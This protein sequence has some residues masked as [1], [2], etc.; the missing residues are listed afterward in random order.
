MAFGATLASLHC[1][2]YN[3]IYNA[4]TA[5]ARA[6]RLAEQQ[7]V[8][9]AR[10]WYRRAADAAESVLSR[11]GNSEWASEA[12]YLAAQ[13][14][15][16]SG[17]CPEAEAHWRRWQERHHAASGQSRQDQLLAV[18]GEL[19]VASCALRRTG[20]V[21]DIGTDIGTDFGTD[22]WKATGTGTVTG[23]VSTA[24]QRLQALDGSADSSWPDV[25]R[26]EIRRWHARAALGAGEAAVADSLLRGLDDDSA[27]WE[28]LL[29]AV[30]TANWPRVERLLVERVR[31]NAFAPALDPVVV[32]LA[33]AAQFHPLRRVEA[34]L[35]QVATARGARAR[36]ALVFGDV[37]V[38]VGD[39]ARADSLF[40]NIVRRH[41]GDSLIAAPAAVRLLALRLRHVDAVDMLSARLVEH[42]TQHGTG[43]GYAQLREPAALF[44]VLHS[45]EDPSGAA[46]FLAGEVARD[47][48]HAPRLA[49]T[50]WESLLDRYPAAPLAPRALAALTLLDTARAGNWRTE[51]QARF[52][53]AAEARWQRQESMVD[54]ADYRAA[55]RL[56]EGRWELALRESAR[57]P[58]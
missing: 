34:E 17:A 40:T 57:V 6:S 5:V 28:R 11:H 35:L 22:T 18:R 31:A 38:R 27:S 20:P 39:V 32:A 23:D 21:T 53:D 24:Y 30:E 55:N 48:L 33:N 16:F 45:T 58:R 52:P 9:S 13:G 2:Y 1:A 12:L 3:G 19:A 8:D 50:V 47:R 15:A 4:R 51:L 44:S 42:E 29:A 7:R 49:R 56:L 14:R 25:L 37:W 26:R 10:V 54:A 36:L 46:L 43:A 41:R